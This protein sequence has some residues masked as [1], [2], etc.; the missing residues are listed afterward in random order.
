MKRAELFAFSVG[1][2]GLGLPR[3]LPIF[4]IT[5]YGIAPDAYFQHSI[6]TVNFAA[7]SPIVAGSA[8]TAD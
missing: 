4:G 1:I 3:W 8:L 5:A 2:H 6:A 7:C